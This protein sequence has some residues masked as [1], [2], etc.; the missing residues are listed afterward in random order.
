MLIEIYD[1]LEERDNKEVAAA[2]LLSY[3]LELVLNYH[4]KRRVD[5]KI[6][7]RGRSVKDLA[8]PF[9]KLVRPVRNWLCVSVPT[10]QRGSRR[11][12]PVFSL[13]CC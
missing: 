13:R 7:F 12:I 5:A 11:I 8:K 4:R 6:T 10:S 3:V 2:G 1:A 9:S